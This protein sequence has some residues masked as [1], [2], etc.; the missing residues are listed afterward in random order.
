MRRAWSEART[1]LRAIFRMWRVWTA[2]AHEDIGDQH[3]RTRLGPIWLLINYLIFAGTF[4][5][6]FHAGGTN[7]GNYAIYVSV[8]LLTWFYMMEVI[9][10]SVTLFVREESFIKGT[11]LPLTT[12]VMRLG[13]QSVIRAAYALVGC[14]AILWLN[15]VRPE[16]AWVWSGLGILLILAVTPAAITVCAFMGAF[17][18]DI[19]FIVANLMRIGLFLTPVL[20]KPDRTS[21]VRHAFYYWDPF[22]YFLEIVRVPVLTGS[23]PVHAFLICGITGLF[24]WALALLLLG[25]YRRQIVFVL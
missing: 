9:T 22:T 8:G 3:K 18:P 12:Y 11:K 20:W 16:L 13:M 4:I 21:G 14:L 17:F 1:E 24:L 23:V 2:L 15:G 6:I 7:A 5:F 25:K 10:L 19:Q